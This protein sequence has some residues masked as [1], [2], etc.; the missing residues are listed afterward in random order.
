MAKFNLFKELWDF[1]KARKKWWLAPMIIILVLLGAL[2]V[3]TESTA[4]APFIYTLF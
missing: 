1:L 2:I 3:L 4:V